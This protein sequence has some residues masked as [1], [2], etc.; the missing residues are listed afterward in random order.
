MTMSNVSSLFSKNLAQFGSSNL[1]VAVAW[2]MAVAQEVQTTCHS[3]V[4]STLFKNEGWQR[5]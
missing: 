1:A 2:S 4:N 5:V 3:T